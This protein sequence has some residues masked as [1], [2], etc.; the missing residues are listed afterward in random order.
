MVNTKTI[1]IENDS[2]MLAVFK[3]IESLK[4]EFRKEVMDKIAQKK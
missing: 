2:R 4:Q 1:V 3:K